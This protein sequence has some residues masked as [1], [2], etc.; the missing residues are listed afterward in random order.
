[1]PKPPLPPARRYNVA[2]LSVQTFPLDGFLAGVRVYLA[3]LHRVPSPSTRPMKAT[4]IANELARHCPPTSHERPRWIAFIGDPAVAD[5][6]IVVATRFI[7]ST[8]SYGESTGSAAYATQVPDGRLP[9]LDHLAVRINAYPADP[10]KVELFH[11]VVAKPDAGLK[12]FARLSD[13]LDRLPFNG[14][15]FISSKDY[16]TPDPIAVAASERF[17]KNW[18]LARRI[19]GE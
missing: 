13:Y 14:P 11:S 4:D 10:L 7:L 3:T 16:G 8:L 18:R 6:E 19:V 2:S 1:M 17:S 12:G 9:M 15:R 5:Q